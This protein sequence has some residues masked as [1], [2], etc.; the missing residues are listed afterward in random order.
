VGGSGIELAN[1]PADPLVIVVTWTGTP[2][3]TTH[4]LEISDDGRTMTLTR[5]RCEGDAIP[6]DLQLRLR[7]REAIESSALAATLVTE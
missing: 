4:T 6:R 5:P 3:D 1:D 2:C 7:F